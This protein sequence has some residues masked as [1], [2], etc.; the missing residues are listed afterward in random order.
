MADQNRQGQQDQNK[1][2]GRNQEGTQPN[3]PDPTRQAKPA[4]PRQGT[5]QTTGD[6]GNLGE[7][8][9][10]QEGRNTQQEKGRQ[11]NR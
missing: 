11:G 8:S 5:D 1:N 3:Q 9:T 6:E 10:R 2:P 4:T 7:R